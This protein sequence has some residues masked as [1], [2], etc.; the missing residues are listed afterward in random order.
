[1]ATSTIEDIIKQQV[2]DQARS[3]REFHEAM[4]ASRTNHSETI[5]AIKNSKMAPKMDPGQAKDWHELL[6]LL[7]HSPMMI[8][9]VLEHVRALSAR[10]NEAVQNE[11]RLTKTE[12]ST[13]ID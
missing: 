11:L 4:E 6:A 12:K 3:E 5:A 10:I 8:A 1:M 7:S 2:E 13:R 9:S